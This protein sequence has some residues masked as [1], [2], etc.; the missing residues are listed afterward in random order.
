[1]KR[2]VKR[3]NIDQVVE[4]VVFSLIKTPGTDLHKYNSQHIE[5]DQRKI[6]AAA[7]AVKHAALTSSAQMLSFVLSSLPSKGVIGKTL[8][9]SSMSYLFDKRPKL[10]NG[11]PYVSP[12]HNLPLPPFSHPES[13]ERKISTASQ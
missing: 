1:M 7:V 5:E 8:S 13:F 3:N 10:G 4:L 12:Q 2:G 11:L 9:E 6:V